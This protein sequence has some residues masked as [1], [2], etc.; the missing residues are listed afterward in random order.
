MYKTGMVFGVFDNLHKG[1]EYFLSES[2]RQCERLVVVVTPDSVVSELKHHTPQQTA[3]VRIDAVKKI[4]PGA[5]V[6]LGDVII[7]SWRVVAEQK[8]DVVF[9]GYDQHDIAIE[10][11]K[12]KLPFHF[13]GAFEPKIYKSSVL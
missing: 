2:V 7:H 1:H 11:K 10:L 4:F 6:I 13:M 9:L 3:S 8:P 5:N 12:L